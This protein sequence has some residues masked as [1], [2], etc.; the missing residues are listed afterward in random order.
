MH[1]ECA[2]NMVRYRGSI[3]AICGERI[4]TG[5]QLQ[6]QTH[7]PEEF[8]LV[9]HQNSVAERKRNI[10]LHTYTK[11]WWEAI[12]P[13]VVQALHPQVPGDAFMA[14]V[15]LMD[16]DIKSAFCQR[17][18]DAGRTRATALATL[19]ELAWICDN[20]DALPAVL[21]ERMK[22][23]LSRHTGRA[24]FRRRQRNG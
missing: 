14:L 15:C 18:M 21:K 2:L 7:R 4:N 23:S 6:Q 19:E 8:A 22:R 11:T 20:Y 10:L 9:E 16:P 1:R 24:R 17:M 5:W 12:W 3:C 13:S